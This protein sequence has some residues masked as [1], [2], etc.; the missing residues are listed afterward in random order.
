MGY[1]LLAGAIVFEIFAI[2]MMKASEGFSVLGPSVACVVLVN[3]NGA[4]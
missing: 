4:A 1:L 3:L 2:T